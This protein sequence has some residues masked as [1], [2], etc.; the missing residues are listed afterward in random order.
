M[1]LEIQPIDMEQQMFIQKVEAHVKAEVSVLA[2]SG[3][4]LP[5]FDRFRLIYDNI[6]PTE[7]SHKGNTLLLFS[8]VNG[9]I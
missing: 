5:I 8:N 9:L 3:S 1:V 7:E 2:L 4:K 6:S